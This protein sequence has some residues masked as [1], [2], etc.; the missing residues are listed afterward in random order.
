[1][2]SGKQGENMVTWSYLSFAICHKRDAKSLYCFSRW[3]GM[4]S[5]MFLLLF[6]CITYEKLLLSS[7]VRK[8]LNL[9]TTF[10]PLT[11]AR[12]RGRPAPGGR[13][14]GRGRG[15]RGRGRRWWHYWT[16]TADFVIYKWNILV[17]KAAFKTKGLFWE[18]KTSISGWDTILWHLC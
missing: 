6:F 17:I 2:K 4:I 7:F 5:R 16:T 14:R 12:G 3:H 8:H 9:N 15:G 10:L 13:G 18:V 11:A 1:M